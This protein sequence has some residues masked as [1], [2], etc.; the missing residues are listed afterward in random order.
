[1]KRSPFQSL[2]VVVTAALFTAAVAAQAQSYPARD[3]T[4]IVPYKPG[5]STDPISRAFAAELA[6]NLAGSSINIENKP[7]GSGTIGISTVLRSKPDGYTI[8]L[9]TYS[10][11]TYQPL[12][13]AGLPYKTPDD[14]TP[15]VKLVEVPA[16]L[17]VRA[18]APWK[19]FEEFMADAKK[20]PGKIRVAVSGI[21]ESSDLAVQQLNQAADTKL[22]SVPFTGGGGE[23]LV[24]LLG[25]R[26]EATVG[27]GPGALGHVKAG[28]IRTLAVFKKGKYDLFP[29][30]ASV[31]DAGYDATLP[32]VYN[33]IA[34]NGLPKDVQDKLVAAS[35]Q[36]AKSE[37]F[38]NFAKSKG[39]IVDIMGPDEMRAELKQYSNTYTKL[40]KYLD[41][42]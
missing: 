8:G 7:G 40:I 28:K 35:L 19:T 30:A 6:K 37:D 9:G 10:A 34:P 41:Q 32:A 18:D 39:Y 27:F 38:L 36:A 16:I 13:N 5:G 17:S 4:F 25:G 23:A 1:M 33:V 12:V 21:R 3:I 11:L 42:K 24:A 22:V 15:I 31:V 29:D 2:K 14:Y 20:N 26:V